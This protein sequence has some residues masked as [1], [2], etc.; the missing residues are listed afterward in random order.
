MVL[1]GPPGGI[2][3]IGAKRRGCENLREQWI[4]I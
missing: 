1:I 4:G 2:R 3:N